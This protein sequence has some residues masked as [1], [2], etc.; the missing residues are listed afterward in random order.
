MNLKPQDVV[1]LL[2]LVAV[3]RFENYRLLAKD[4]FMSLSEVHQCLE[5]AKIAQLL[6]SQ[7]HMPRM[8]ALEEFLLHGA[9]YSFPAQRGQLTRGLPTGYAASPLDKLIVKTEDYPPV[10]PYAEGATRGYALEPLYKTVPK[11]ALVDKQLYELL[12]LFDA[13]REGRARER[14][15]AAEE[16]SKRLRQKRAP[17]SNKS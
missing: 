10:W 6:D 8:R 7:R 3:G 4:L 5:R 2:K 13:I 1:V 9:K 11:A 14:V 16:L 15:L 17:S 12:A